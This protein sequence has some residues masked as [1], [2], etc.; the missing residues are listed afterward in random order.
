MV[1]PDVPLASPSDMTIPVYVEDGP[2]ILR[3]IREHHAEW[4]KTASVG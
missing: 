1:R 2:S 3:L 4:V